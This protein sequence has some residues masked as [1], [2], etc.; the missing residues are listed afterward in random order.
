MQDK[1][2]NQKP[3]PKV[4]SDE[5]KKELKKQHEK[6]LKQKNNQEIIRK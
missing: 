3:V 2:K 1:N 6:K 5:E 4:L